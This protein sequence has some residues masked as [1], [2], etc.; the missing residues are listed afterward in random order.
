MSRGVVYRLVSQTCAKI[1]CAWRLVLTGTPLQNDL[2]ELY[3][4]LNF[5]LP[6]VFTSPDP[7]SG[8]FDLGPNSHKVDTSMLS[9]AHLLL[10]PF[11]LRRLKKARPFLLSSSLPFFHA[12]RTSC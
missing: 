11:I 7:F 4:M 1:R 12:H 10:K 9:R 2:H 8:A 5:L 3:C 6:D